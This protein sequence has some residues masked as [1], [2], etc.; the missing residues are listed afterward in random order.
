[1]IILDIPSISY[2]SI[3]ILEQ[4]INIKNQGAGRLNIACN[5]SFEDVRMNGYGI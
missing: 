2:Q 1:M 3:V 5:N 4:V